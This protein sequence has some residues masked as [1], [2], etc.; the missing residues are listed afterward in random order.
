MNSRMKI[1]KSFIILAVVI[2]LVTIAS[3]IIY[4]EFIQ[5]KERVFSV[6]KEHLIGQKVHLLQKYV[7][8]VEKN[9]DAN[10]PELILDNAAVAAELVHELSLLQGEDVKYLYMLYRDKDVWFLKV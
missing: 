4:F 10:L 8:N 7:R 6:I 9:Y 3:L 1:N 2:P 5:A